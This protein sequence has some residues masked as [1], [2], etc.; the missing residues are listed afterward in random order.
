[1]R[2][3]HFCKRRSNCSNGE[4]WDALLALAEIVGLDY[5]GVDCA[6]LDGKVL[7]FEANANML[8]QNF[9]DDRLFAYKQPAFEAIAQAFNAMIW[10]RRALL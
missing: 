8:V 9:Y 2:R 4:R 6:L 3:R 7:I 1:M 10:E 5:F